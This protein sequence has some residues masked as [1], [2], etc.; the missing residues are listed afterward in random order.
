ML[1]GKRHDVI[2]ENSINIHVKK[3]LFPRITD[4]SIHHSLSFYWPSIPDIDREYG[5]RED[6][7]CYLISFRLRYPMM[8]ESFIVENQFQ[9][10]NSLEF[11][12]NKC[13]KSIPTH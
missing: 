7:I 10:A 13:M 12:A 5:K 3:I 8:S 11:Y 4:A 1:E 2:V 6:G 9:T